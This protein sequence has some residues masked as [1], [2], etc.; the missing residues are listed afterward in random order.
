MRKKYHC[1]S[2]RERVNKMTRQIR[3]WSKKWYL[4]FFVLVLLLIKNH[5]FFPLLK[6][7]CSIVLFW[8]N[9]EH[10]NWNACSCMNIVLR[11]LRGLNFFIFIGFKISCFYQICY[12]CQ[13]KRC[14]LRDHKK[15]IKGW[16]L[17]SSFTIFRS[18]IIY[19]YI[20]LFLKLCEYLLH[21]VTTLETLMF[22][23]TYF[24]KLSTQIK[25]GK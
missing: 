22:F 23:C 5:S 6:L 1:V 19:I 7:C 20:L 11:S 14:Y 18:G 12:H 25:D 16:I 4:Y 24:K 9:L 21:Q 13:N 3:I 15:W 8:W 10:A 2:N 17:F